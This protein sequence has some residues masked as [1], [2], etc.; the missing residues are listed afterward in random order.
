MENDN[1]NKI[2]GFG[3]TA[4]KL[5]K[6]QI[7][8]EITFVILA[9]VGVFLKETTPYLLIISLLILAS[10]YFFKGASS[11]KSDNSI[12]LAFWKL[13]CWTMSVSAL[14]I[15]FA[16][17]NWQAGK[18][19]LITSG[20]TN[21]ISLFYYLFAKFTNKKLDGKLFLGIVIRLIVALVIIGY[22]MFLSGIKLK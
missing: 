9:I 5:T 12:D 14:G 22:I 1:K 18:I 15:L 16:V 13:F 4:Q 8:I 21:I 7:Y 2:S 11:V 17:M 19:L 6:I 3:G 10:L 20:L